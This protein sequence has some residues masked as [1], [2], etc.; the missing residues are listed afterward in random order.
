MEKFYFANRKPKK[1]DKAK[2]ILDKVD[3]NVGIITRSDLK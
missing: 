3:F 2:L 1:S